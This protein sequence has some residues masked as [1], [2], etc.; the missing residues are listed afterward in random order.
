[1]RIDLMNELFCMGLS[2]E[3]YRQVEKPVAEDNRRSIVAWS[4]CAIVFWIL[5]LAMS[6]NSDAYKACRPVYL[7]A[8][9]ICIITLAGAHFLVKKV[10]GL[11]SPI[12]YLFELSVLGA[13]IGIAVCQPHVR[14]VTMIAFAVIVPTCIIDNTVADT[15]LHVITVISYVL[16]GRNTIE[17]DIYS[18]GLM[19]L[20]L[21][22][23]AGIIVGHVINK[24][25]FERY[26]YAESAM[27]LAE[28]QSLYAYHDQMT[29]L[30]NRRAYVE[31]LEK[32]GDDAFCIVMA[33]VNGLKQANDTYGHEAGDTL[34]KGAADCLKTAFE[35]ADVYRVG[36][37]EFCVIVKQQPIQ[38]SMRCLEKLEQVSGEKGIS[39]SYGIA[40]GIG[41]DSVES[42]AAEADQKMYE[43]KHDYYL[44]SGKDRRRR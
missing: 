29:G 30:K 27:K 35:N 18:W 43:H 42:V 9:I 13:G 22:S 31:D 41:K 25:R 44:K 21:F 5:S 26:V 28:I 12:M 40:R 19:N 7:A 10:P 16:L 2:K 23:V 32:I 8:L 4:I 15:I 39:I 36:G 34:L 6:L 24:A 38:D 20:V 14:T 1:M 33:D 3:Q 11:L 37:D 17:P